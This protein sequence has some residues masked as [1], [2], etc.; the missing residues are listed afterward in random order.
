MRVLFVQ[1][2]SFNA[3]AA[4]APDLNMVSVVVDGRAN[5]AS[6]IPAAIPA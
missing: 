6:V 2:V 5:G 4:P 3:A 1:S